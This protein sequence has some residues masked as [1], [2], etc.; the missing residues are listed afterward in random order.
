MMTLMLPLRN[1]PKRKSAQS[2]ERSRR[3]YSS[4]AL[5][6]PSADASTRSDCLVAW[7]ER[8]MCRMNAI[9]RVASHSL[10]VIPAGRRPIGTVSSS[11]MRRTSK[12]TVEVE[13]GCSVL[14]EQPSI[15]STWWSAFLIPSVFLY[16]DASAH[17]VWVKQR[18]SSVSSMQ[19]ATW[20]SSSTTSCR[21]RFISIRMSIG[22]FNKT[23]LLNTQPTSHVDG[24]TIT[25]STSSTSIHTRLTSIRSKTYGE[26]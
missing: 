7:V 24:F 4:T 18:Y 26:F 11:A 15:R 23:M 16:G 22:G 10:K 13:S 1:T 5:L 3:N 2:Q 6:A 21:Q 9:F 25:V 8:S 20:I 17:V 14:S 19:N 12:C